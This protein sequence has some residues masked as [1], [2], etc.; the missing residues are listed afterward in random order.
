[1]AN[2]AIVLKSVATEVAPPRFARVVKRP[3]IKVL[4]TINE[5]EAC[6]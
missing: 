3:I 6:A 5:E 4:A 1:M 2:F